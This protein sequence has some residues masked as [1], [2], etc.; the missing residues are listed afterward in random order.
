MTNQKVEIDIHGMTRDEAK[1]YL[2]RFLN[3][4][5]GSVREVEVIHGWSGG[6]ALMDMV[7]KGLRHPKI[8][9]KVV[10]MNPGVTILML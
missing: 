10:S 6:T 8:R 2:I 1:R 5:N 7:R 4:V 3:R 9:A